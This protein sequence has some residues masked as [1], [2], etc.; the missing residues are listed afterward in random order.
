[1]TLSNAAYSRHKAATH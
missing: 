1:M